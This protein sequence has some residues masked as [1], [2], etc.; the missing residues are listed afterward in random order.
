M[1]IY[2]IT[3]K[4]Q[5]IQIENRLKNKNNGLIKKLDEVIIRNYF[6]ENSDMY[7]NE[8][9]DLL[10]KSIEHEYKK[11]EE[12]YEEKY[13]KMKIQTITI[14]II[15]SLLKKKI[16]EKK[17]IFELDICLSI[18][19]KENLTD[20]KI[21]CE[22]WEE[23]IEKFKDIDSYIFVCNKGI[24][25][26]LKTLFKKCRINQTIFFTSDYKSPIIHIVEQFFLLK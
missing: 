26:D 20:K 12:A 18:L 4:Y 3:Q 22:E 25:E 7:E 9:L 2:L 11:S 8:F 5:E 17:N 10:K 1:I 6:E 23:Y 24:M 21:I 14:D 13:K 16:N 15:D 19:L